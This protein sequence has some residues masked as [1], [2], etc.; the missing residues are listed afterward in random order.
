MKPEDYRQ[1]AA[2][3]AKCQQPLWLWADSFA[4]VASYLGRNPGLSV[5]GERGD[6]IVAAALCGED[7]RAGYIHHL[8]V[9]PREP[10]RELARAVLQR[11]LMHLRALGVGGCY[12]FTERGVRFVEFSRRAPCGFG[13][14]VA[15]LL[16]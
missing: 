8:A 15:A 10:E 14:S 1:V 12:L 7:G 2:L 5:V 11:C 13:E 6:S 9:D 4:G 3:W 16:V